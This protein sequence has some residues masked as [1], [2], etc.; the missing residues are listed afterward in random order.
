MLTD[1]FLYLNGIEGET[2]DVKMVD[3]QGQFAM[4]ITG[5]STSYE[6]PIA[7]AQTATGPTI[8][9]CKAEPIVVTKSLDV[10]T[11]DLLMATWGG[12]VIID[13]WIACFRADAAKG[14][15]VRYLTI[16]MQNIVITTYSIS[17]AE[18]DL[19]QEELGLSAGYVAYIY[20]AQMKEGG[21]DGKLAAG[22]NF[23]TGTYGPNEIGIIK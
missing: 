18:G 8:E 16:E 2:D 3:D 14:T 11:S 5:W 6:Q 15:P 9:R 7:M 12:R 10:A 17:G 13:G 4:E 1:M 20:Q 21:A 22:F 23:I 19:P